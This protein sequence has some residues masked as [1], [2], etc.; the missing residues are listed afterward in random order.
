MYMCTYFYMVI[1]LKL[2]GNLWFLWFKI[3]K[4]EEINYNQDQVKIWIF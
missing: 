3:S 1:Q 2:L 4:I